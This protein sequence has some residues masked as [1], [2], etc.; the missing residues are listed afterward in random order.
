MVRAWFSKKYG[1]FTALIRGREFVWL[2]DRWVD[3]KAMVSGWN[4]YQ[5][6]RDRKFS[7][8]YQKKGRFI[9]ERKIAYLKKN[10]TYNSVTHTWES[11][12]I[13]ERKWR[14]KVF[15]PRREESFSSKI[16]GLLKS[17]GILVV[18]I[19]VLVIYLNPLFI[20]LYGVIQNPERKQ[21]CQ[22]A[23]AYLNTIRESY[24]RGPLKWD[25]RIYELAVYRARDM[26]ER[27]YFDHKTPEGKCA[28]DFKEQFNI[29]EAGS[30]PENIG[31]MTSY[32][33]GTVTGTCKEA[34]NTWLESRGHRYNLLY[35]DHIAGAIGCYKY[36]CVFLALSKGLFTCASAS[37]GESYWSNVGKQPFEV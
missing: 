10:S 20:D 3:I 29:T 18:I 9:E 35:P 21:D 33:S 16:G 36:Y 7:F 31:G 6:F 4:R 12:S 34:V 19:F 14:P 2:N 30:M 24:G 8:W 17:L 27:H 28:V 23:F 13:P 11:R 26:Y 22:D 37:E 32:G 5:Q 1:R 15:I 25:D